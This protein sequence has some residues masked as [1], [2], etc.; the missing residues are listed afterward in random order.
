MVDV[1]TRFEIY[2]SSQP[3]EDDFKGNGTGV[4]EVGTAPSAVTGGK[5]LD[6]GVNISASL[7]PGA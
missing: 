2:Y 1:H 5:V 7:E 3:V 6:P 4:D